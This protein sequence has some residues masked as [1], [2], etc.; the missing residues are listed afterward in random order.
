MNL[1]QL[2]NLIH[3]INLMCYANFLC[4]VYQ[5]LY[6]FSHSINDYSCVLYF[7]YI[8]QITSYVYDSCLIYPYFFISFYM[9]MPA[10]SKEVDTGKDC[11][12]LRISLYATVISICII[13]YDSNRVTVMTQTGRTISVC[14]SNC[15]PNRH[16][17]LSIY[18]VI[19]R[20]S[21]LLRFQ[22]ISRIHEKLLLSCMHMRYSLSIIF[23]F[24]K[25]TFTYLLSS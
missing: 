2:D 24:I 18:L 6:H 5:I 15:I 14:C 23:I 9:F 16:V 22:Y 12:Y 11:L 21:V 1:P 17:H 19:S 20:Q 25:S 3:Y 4:F 7:H 8:L 13:L 10:F